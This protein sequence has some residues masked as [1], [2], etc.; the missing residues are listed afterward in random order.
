MDEGIDVTCGAYVRFDDALAALA[1]PLQIDLTYVT[2]PLQDA[3]GFVLVPCTGMC[4]HFLSGLS[5]V[6][7]NPGVVWNNEIV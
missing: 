6:L 1:A 2:V 3:H 7:R 5:I 4:P